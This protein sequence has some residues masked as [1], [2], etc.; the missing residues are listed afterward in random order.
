MRDA[1]E[2]RRDRRR[3]ILN[4]AYEEQVNV[5][6][7]RNEHPL[8]LQV[9]QR[10]QDRIRERNPELQP[11]FNENRDDRYLAR[12]LDKEVPGIN[13]IRAK[14]AYG[15]NMNDAM[16]VVNLGTEF[17]GGLMDEPIRPPINERNANTIDNV[18]FG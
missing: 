3:G 6:M 12:L 15:E 8:N 14:I 16:K 9:L 17:R 2:N 18:K 1:E 5:E 7:R 10:V 13:K 11:A 4:D